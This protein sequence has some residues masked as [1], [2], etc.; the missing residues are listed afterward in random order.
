[1]LLDDVVSLDSRL[2]FSLHW[3]LMLCI[4]CSLLASFSCHRVR[5][6]WVLVIIS[7]SSFVV[8][9]LGAS[10]EVLILKL[11]SLVCLLRLIDCRLIDW[12]MLLVMV[13]MWTE[14]DCASWLVV[15]AKLSVDV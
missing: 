10:M 7:W 4:L 13:L 5:Y 8:D 12:L 15:L 14:R 2:T 11:R 1:M 3:L 9:L 6:A